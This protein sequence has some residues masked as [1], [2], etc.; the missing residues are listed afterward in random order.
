L[1]RKSKDFLHQSLLPE[2][3]NLVSNGYRFLDLSPSQQRQM[4]RLVVMPD[5]EPGT[6]RIDVAWQVTEE[7]AT[8]ARKMRDRGDCADLGG[9]WKA[10]CFSPKEPQA[11]SVVLTLPISVDPQRLE[12]YTKDANGKGTLPFY[13]ENIEC[14]LY[15]GDETT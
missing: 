15:Y 1:E 11:F 5:D 8:K 4:P 6:S 10:F 9:G 13:V 7:L 3:Q 14:R 12:E 2:T